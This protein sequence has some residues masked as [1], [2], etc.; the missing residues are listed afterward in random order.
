MG[1]T[2]PH[3]IEIFNSRVSPIQIS[4]LAYCNTLGFETVDYLISDPNLIFEDEEKHYSEKI[5]RMPN[6]WNAHSGFIFERKKNTLPSKNSKLFKFGSFNNFNKISEETIKTWS[7][8][9][10][11]SKNFRL[12]LKSSEFCDSMELINHFKENGVENQLEILDRSNFKNKQDHMD[13]YKK[14]D[15]ALDTFPYNGVTTTFEALWM[16]VLLWY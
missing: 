9:L 3:R 15:L 6:I 13:L 2:A 7:K 4:W 8:I 14:I 1:Y 5:L 12:V 11:E 16:N 10:K